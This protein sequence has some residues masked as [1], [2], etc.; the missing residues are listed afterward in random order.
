MQTL[1]A[2][3]FRLGYMFFMQVGM[4]QLS[5]CHGVR[6]RPGIW[7]RSARLRNAQRL[8]VIRAKCYDFAVT[9]I[10]A[11]SRYIVIVTFFGVCRDFCVWV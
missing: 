10:F 6:E 11:A 4:L 7:A 2:I 9:S 1:A 5:F 3:I 8:I